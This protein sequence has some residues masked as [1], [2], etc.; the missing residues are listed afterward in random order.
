ML[1]Q[2][3]RGFETEIARLNKRAA[4]IGIAPITYTNAGKRTVE[5]T[6]VCV[7]EGVDGFEEEVETIPVEVTV[8]EL[9]LPTFEDY[10]WTLAGTLTPVEGGGAFVDAHVKNLDTKAWEQVDPCRCQHCNSDRKRNLTYVV[11]NKDTAQEL[12]VGRTCFADYVGHKGL[13]ALEFQTLLVCTLGGGDEDFFPQGGGGGRISVVSVR[14]CIAMAEYMV[15]E[16]GGWRFN[17]KND[18][19][20]IEVEGTHRTAGRCA[21]Q[22]PAGGGWAGTLDKNPGAF[23]KADEIIAAMKDVELAED[24]DFGRALQYCMAFESVPQKKAGLVAYAGQY[25]RQRAERAARD[26]KRATMKH[27]G[28]VGKREVFAGL[29]V[30]RSIDC[31]SD[32]GPSTLYIFEDAQG[33]ELSWK[34]GT[35]DLRVGEVVELKATVVEHRTW[36]DTPQ[37]KLSRAKVLATANEAQA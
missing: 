30:T 23:L 22:S 36:K 12:Q 17:R 27:V 1:V 28:T 37:T 24:D 13:L 11:R 6:M 2:D 3:V 21:V 31:T 14:R 9:V 33:N 4:K 34:T 5:R 18:F 10:R 8:F 20:D 19:G 15:E 7:Q 29:T 32:F 35:V 26:A 25:L 16:Q